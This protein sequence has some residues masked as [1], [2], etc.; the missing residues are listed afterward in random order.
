MEFRNVIQLSIMVKCSIYIPLKLPIIMDEEYIVYIP[1]RI[2]EGLES[3]SWSDM[4]V[5]G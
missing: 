4:V 1:N 5:K 2:I 3:F